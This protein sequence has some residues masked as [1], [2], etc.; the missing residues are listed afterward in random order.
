MKEWLATIADGK[1]SNYHN[2]EGLEDIYVHKWR[3][4]KLVGYVGRIGNI[5]HTKVLGKLNEQLERP[6]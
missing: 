6:G 2:T 1:L 5:K 3:R 4:L